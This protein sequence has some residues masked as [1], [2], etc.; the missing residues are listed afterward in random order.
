M[1]VAPGRPSIGAARPDGLRG[2]VALAAF[3]LPL[4]A[5]GGRGKTSQTPDTPRKPRTW[6]RLPNEPGWGVLCFLFNGGDMVLKFS[7]P[8]SRSL[9]SWPIPISPSGPG[10]S[11]RASVGDKWQ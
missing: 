2:F 5:E 9:Y 8:L 6:G 7:G 11:R 4:G 3:D 1:L 10:W